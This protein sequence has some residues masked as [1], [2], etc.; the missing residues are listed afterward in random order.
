MNWFKRHKG[1]TA[2]FIITV[3]AFI[4]GF[5]PGLNPSGIGEMVG[6]AW[7]FYLLAWGVAGRKH[8]W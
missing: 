3:L 4:A 1:W 7:V 6:F 5:I 8:G 2:M